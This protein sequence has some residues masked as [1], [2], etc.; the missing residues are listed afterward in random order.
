M[1]GRNTK[2]DDKHL[3][4][5]AMHLIRLYML[6]IDIM[7][8]EEINTYR[9]GSDHELLM[10]IRNGKY[11]DSNSQFNEAFFELHEYYKSRFDY[12]VKNTSLPVSPNYKAAEALLVEINKE[13]LDIESA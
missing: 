9:E 5:H 2:K 4:K 8:K 10:N 11:L 12:A 1:D 13:G 6:G 7:E 3:C